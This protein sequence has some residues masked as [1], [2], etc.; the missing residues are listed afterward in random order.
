M[1]EFAIK[2]EAN[3]VRISFDKVFGFPNTTCHAGGYDLEATIEIKSG[4]FTVKSS[5]YTSTGEFFDFYEQLKTCNNLLSGTASYANYEQNIILKVTYDQLGHTHI[6]GTYSEFNSFE[7]KLN[8]DFL[9]DQS[10]IK[11]AIDGL[12][13]IASE[14]GNMDGKKTDLEK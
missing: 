7:N 1:Y 8:F 12:E 9:S 11:S 5:L 6:H 14:Y 3:F 13:L 4:G 2:G 10:F